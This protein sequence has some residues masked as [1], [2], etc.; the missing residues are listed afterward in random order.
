MAS[1]AFIKREGLFAV[2]AVGGSAELTLHVGLHVYEVCSYFFLEYPRVT[3]TAFVAFYM[4]AMGE[5]NGAYALYLRLTRLL[6]V[7]YNIAEPAY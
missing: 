2:V 3:G 5:V 4:L 7:K 1:I 6:P